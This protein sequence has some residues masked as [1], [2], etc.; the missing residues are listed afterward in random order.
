MSEVFAFEGNLPEDKVVSWG[1]GAVRD[2]ER[3][4]NPALRRECTSG[5]AQRL[6]E[7]GHL[8]LL[9]SPVEIDREY[10]ARPLV[11]AVVR[12]DA[13]HAPYLIVD[14]G[15]NVSIGVRQIGGKK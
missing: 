2:G 13:R 15:R 10:A 4:W 1:A 12:L 9:P 14:T 5:D 8:T 3:V 7:D 11:V 6:I